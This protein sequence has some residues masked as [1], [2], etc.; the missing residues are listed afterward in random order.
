MLI[1]SAEKIV[2][3]TRQKELRLNAMLGLMDT[4]LD[5]TVVKTLP[6]LF[7]AIIGWVMTTHDHTRILVW[8]HNMDRRLIPHER[9]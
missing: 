1:M 6:V 2:V 7:A 3:G 8:G 9:C 4:G 5:K